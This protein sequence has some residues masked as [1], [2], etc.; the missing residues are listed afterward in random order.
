MGKYIIER[1]EENFA[2][3][4]KPEGGTINVEKELIPE[5]KEGDAVILED[6]IYRVDSELT[7]RRKK[8]ISEKMRKLFA[9]NQNT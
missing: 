1:F 4:E 8:I 2:V 7:A 9:K 6:G 5:G 3:L